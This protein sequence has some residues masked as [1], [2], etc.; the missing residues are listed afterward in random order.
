MDE[1]RDSRRQQII[2][3]AVSA[4]NRIIIDGSDGSVEETNYLTAKVA[5]KI[6]QTALMPFSSEMLQKDL[7]LKVIR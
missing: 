4:A 5:E 1:A 6:V 7:G 2:S 3:Q